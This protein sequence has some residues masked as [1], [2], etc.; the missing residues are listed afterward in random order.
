MVSD[1]NNTIQKIGTFLGVKTDLPPIERNIYNNKNEHIYNEWAIR[2]LNNY[3]R[4][5]YEKSSGSNSLISRFQ[6]LL[7]KKW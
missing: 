3:K 1:M 2:F 7:N 5:N 4:F 6:H